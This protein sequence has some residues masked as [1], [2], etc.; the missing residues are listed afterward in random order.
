MVIFLALLF[1]LLA[2]ETDP[3]TSLTRLLPLSAVARHRTSLAFASAMRGVIVCALKLAAFHALF[4]W[5]SFSLF[6]VHLVYLSTVASAVGLLLSF[7][8]DPQHP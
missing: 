7:T 1:Y 3:L 4:T 5:L 6:S 2:A 8:Q